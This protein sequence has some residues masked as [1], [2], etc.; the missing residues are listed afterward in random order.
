[1]VSTHLTCNLIAVEKGGRI[2][3]IKQQMTNVLVNKVKKVLVTLL[4]GSDID[5]KNNQEVSLNVTI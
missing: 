3:D 4:R 2:V 5:M 1:M